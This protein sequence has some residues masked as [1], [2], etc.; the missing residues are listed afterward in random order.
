[1]PVAE[2]RA[3]DLL[4]PQALTKRIFHFQPTA[5]NLGIPR[6][7]V[8]CP[9]VTRGGEAGRLVNAYIQ[10][11]WAKAWTP[12]I[13]RAQLA[14]VG[15]TRPTQLDN[16]QAAALKQKGRRALP[17]SIN[18]IARHVDDF[19]EWWEAS[20]S[21]DDTDED[22]HERLLRAQEDLL[23]AYGDDMG[24]GEWSNSGIPVSNTTINHRQ[25]N[26]LNFLLWTKFEGLAPE[27]IVSATE[28]KV[29]VASFSGAPLTISRP[30]FAVVRRPD[31]RRV[32]LPDGDELRGHIA[33]ILDPAAQVGALL[34]YGCGLRLSE[35]INLRNDALVQQGSGNQKYLRVT[36]KGNK[37]RLVEIEPFLIKQIIAYQDFTRSLRLQ[38]KS[39]FGHI[40]L[41]REDG[42]PFPP[43]AF[44]RAFRKSGSISPHMGRH[45]YAVNFLLQAAECRR[46]ASG[47]LPPDLNVEL[48]TELIRLQ[49]N[50]GHNHLATTEMYLVTLSQRL[51][52]VSLSKL[53]EDRL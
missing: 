13:G 36:G 5:L 29:R 1:M 49:Q 28:R 2:I 8:G 20:L 37:T 46:N 30:Q 4:K 22:V 21:L 11:R 17:Q 19:V 47:E 34:I 42:S 51:F 16:F 15:S 35:V 7:F 3:G 44:Y 9:Y 10:A 39:T 6:K 41:L 38:Q 43:K 32:R 23:E 33:V 27:F 52:P 31:P 53:F 12:S 24:T 45:W 50:L 26:A 48:Q 14:E 25:I 40:L 18:V